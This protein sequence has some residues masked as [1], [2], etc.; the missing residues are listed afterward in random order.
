M[1]WIMNIW[2]FSFR[3]CTE[4]RKM[5]QRRDRDRQ[6]QATGAELTSIK[7]TQW[8]R[9]ISSCIPVFTSTCDEVR[10]LRDWDK[11]A[12]AQF[13]LTQHRAD[14]RSE[15]KVMGE[16]NWKQHIEAI[17]NGILR[18]IFMNFTRDACIIWIYNEHMWPLLSSWFFFMSKAQ[19]ALFSRH[20]PGK[21]RRS[22]MM[23][24]I[25]VS[26]LARHYGNELNVSH[27]LF[28]FYAYNNDA[29][30]HL[31]CM[32]TWSPDDWTLCETTFSLFIDDSMDPFWIC[33][34]LRSLELSENSDFVVDAS[35]ATS[36]LLFDQ[37][38]V[39][40]SWKN[41]S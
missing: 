6:E 10:T 2:C 39:D 16:I 30:T 34:N 8:D 37:V 32:M 26:S 29:F 25:L 11:T 27:F 14:Q 23:R 17:V 38:W 20:S 19:I 36:I 40:E 31:F 33:S 28:F 21:K 5:W 35:V 41:V 13:V 1:T 24:K 4:H 7:D 9:R 22:S 15:S 18:L 12:I 3:W